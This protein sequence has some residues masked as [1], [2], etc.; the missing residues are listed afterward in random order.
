MRTLLLDRSTWDLTLDAA[1]N[2]A[3]ADAPYARAQDAASAIKVFE[4]ECWYNTTKGIPYFDQV[5]G[6]FP[7]LSLVQ[8]L[9]VSA[10][11]S[12]PGVTD[13]RVFFSG[14]EGRRL[15]GQVQITDETSTVS[16][17]GF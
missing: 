10:A 12:V 7:P 13:A 5:L 8:E 9:M 6:H 15:S 3:V 14:L 16:I 4:G 17:A 11:K 1:G 2:V